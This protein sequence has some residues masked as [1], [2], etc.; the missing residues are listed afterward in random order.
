[1]VTSKKYMFIPETRKRTTSVTEFLF[2]SP[3]KKCDL[4][5][6]APSAL[7]D[8]VRQM[9]QNSIRTIFKYTS[10]IYRKRTSKTTGASTQGATQGWTWRVTY[11]TGA[12]GRKWLD[13]WQQ[14]YS[15]ATRTT[16][17]SGGYA[18]WRTCKG[19]SQYDT[20]YFPLWTGKCSH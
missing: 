6:S 20:W 17:C 12:T 14:G 15:T 3:I 10:L 16:I 11:G 1:M 4:L 18:Q 2:L 8:N 19:S 9:R 5:Y 13:K 7:I